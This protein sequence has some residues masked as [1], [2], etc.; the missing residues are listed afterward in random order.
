MKGPDWCQGR[1]KLGVWNSGERCWGKRG[2]HSAALHHYSFHETAAIVSIL[3]LE[4]SVSH[5]TED[6]TP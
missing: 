6:Y 3:V 1:H 2:E 5:L 4:F